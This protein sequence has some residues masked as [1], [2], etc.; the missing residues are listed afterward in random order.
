MFAIE[1]TGDDRL[2]Y[3]PYRYFRWANDFEA[4]GPDGQPVSM[5][6]LR[7][8][9][10]K[11]PVAIHELG[12]GDRRVVFGMEYEIKLYLFKRDRNCWYLTRA[13]NPSD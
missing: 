3:F 12:S 4:L 6:A 11:Y 2:R 8:R 5:E 9:Q 1:A 13:T 7:A 10:T